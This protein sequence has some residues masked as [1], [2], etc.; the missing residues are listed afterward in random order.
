MEIVKHKHS[1]ILKHGIDVSASYIQL[2]TLLLFIRANNYVIRNTTQTIIILMDIY[3]NIILIN[4]YNTNI[5]KV[6]T[7]T[8]NVRMVYMRLLTIRSFLPPFHRSRKI[9]WNE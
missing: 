2:I 4:Q 9:R 6:G 3:I 8:T 5:N 7:S 1:C